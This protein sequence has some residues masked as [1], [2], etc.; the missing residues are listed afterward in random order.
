MPGRPSLAVQQYYANTR[1]AFWPIVCALVKDTAPSYDV[2]QQYSY[3]QRC[4]LLTEAG[5]GAWDVLASCTRPGSLD[6]AIVRETEQ[7]NSIAE[8]ISS[9]NGLRLVACNGRTAHT[10]FK[11][12]ISAQLATTK[13]ELV[14]LPSSSPAM[15]SLSLEK[16]HQKWKAL[17]AGE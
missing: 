13:F 7:P 3:E 12:H 15:A 11:R 1:N 16:K 6:S 8:L 10:L 9:H 5:F 4:K 17:L 2:H 14:L